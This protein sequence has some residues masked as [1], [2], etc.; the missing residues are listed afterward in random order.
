MY[1]QKKILGGVCVAADHYSSPGDHA[2][3]LDSY[4]HGYS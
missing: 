4:Q 3:P 1:P 2:A